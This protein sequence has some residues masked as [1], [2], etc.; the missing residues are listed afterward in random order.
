MS[1]LT[2]ISFVFAIILC[3]FFQ[4]SFA[5]NSFTQNSASMPRA[6][7]VF[8]ELFGPGLVISANYD[9]RF[10]QRR[11]GLGGRVGVGFLAESGNSILTLPV[12][13]NYLL[14]KKSKYFEVGLG[15]TFINIGGNDR[16]YLSLDDVTGTIGTMTFGYRYQPEDGGFH[17]RAAITPIFN[18]SAFLPYFAGIGFGY[19]F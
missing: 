19:T 4:N 7:N 13:V 14:G 11:D 16:G 2:K 5:Q 18:S 8:V 17:F 15:A 3:A 6:Q 10:G 9:T 1:T 12:Q